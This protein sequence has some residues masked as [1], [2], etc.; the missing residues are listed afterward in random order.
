[1]SLLLLNAPRCPPGELPLYSMLQGRWHCDE[2]IG[3]SFAENSCLL[4]GK[5]GRWDTETVPEQ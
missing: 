2:L 3:P 1:M 5:Q 4:R